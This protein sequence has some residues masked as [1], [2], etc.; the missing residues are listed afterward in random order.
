MIQAYAKTTGIPLRTAQH[1]AKNGNSKFLQFAVSFSPGSPDT[2]APSPAS[3]VGDPI[4]Q[5]EQI[6]AHN[7]D[8]CETLRVRMKAAPHAFI[9][10]YAKAFATAQKSWRDSLAHRTRLQ[11]EAG[12]LVS[13][14]RLAAIER[15]FLIPL[16]E[17]LRVMPA[18]LGPEAN[19]LDP[20]RG[21]AAC[22]A[23][24]EAKPYPA[25]RAIRDAV[26]VEKISQPAEQGAGVEGG[27]S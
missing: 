10:G 4:S 21:I 18:E 24:L 2:P 15:E 12:R 5:A 1:H 22:S 9:D 14:D 25:L 11:V 13:A 7:W 8:L 23:W 16:T 19:P 20:R 6:V 3:P 27:G 17:V 26:T